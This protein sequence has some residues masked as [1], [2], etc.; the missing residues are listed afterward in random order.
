MQGSELQRGEE[1]DDDAVIVVDPDEIED[2]RDDDKG[3][4]FEPEQSLTDDDEPLFR[5]Q[6]TSAI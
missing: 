4:F 5:A 3:P 6:R 1:K 2:A